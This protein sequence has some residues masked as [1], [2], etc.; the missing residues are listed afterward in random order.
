MLYKELIKRLKAAE[1]IDKPSHGWLY[2]NNELIGNCG[3]FE[4]N[5][6]DEINLVLGGI[7]DKPCFLFDCDEEKWGGIDIDDAIENELCDWFEDAAG[8]VSHYDELKEFI[9][10]WNA[11]QHVFQYFPNYGRVIVLDRVKFNQLVNG[12]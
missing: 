7:E 12:E 4:I 10:K 6:L 1:I 5:N 3:Y 2:S 9:S 11:K 8:Q